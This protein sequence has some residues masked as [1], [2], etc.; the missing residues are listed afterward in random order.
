MI[1][2][3]SCNDRLRKKSDCKRKPINAVALEKAVLRDLTERL[4]GRN[5]VKCLISQYRKYTKEIFKNREEID[6]INKLKKEL[7]KKPIT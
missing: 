4:F 7:R 6:L 5:Q 1:T 2:F 3:Y